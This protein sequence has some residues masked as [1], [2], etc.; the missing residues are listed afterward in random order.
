MRVADV[1]PGQAAVAM[2]R[3]E[4][5]AQQAHLRHLRGEVNIVRDLHRIGAATHQL[6][7]QRECAL[8][9]AGEAERARVGEHG[10]VQAGRDFGRN[11]HAG[12]ARQTENH[13]GGGAGVGIDPVHVGKGTRG[14]VVVD[15]DEVMVFQSGE[16]GARHAIAFQDDGGLGFGSL[17]DVQQHRIA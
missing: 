11:L 6:L 8:G 2:Q 1:H 9:G 14:S 4:G 5:R 7:R 12:L 16:P 17:F 10:G 15:V 3:A 13:L